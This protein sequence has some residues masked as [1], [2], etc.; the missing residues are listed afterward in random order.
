M[1]TSEP[2][3]ADETDEGFTLVEI[4]V[5]IGLLSVV[6]VASL[7]VF[8][9]MLASTATTRLNTQGKNLAQERLEQIRD[10][11]FHVDRQN[12]PFLDLLDLYYTNAKSVGTP[13]PVT[14]SGLTLSGNYVATGG[15]MNG[16]PAAPYYRT[17]TG[18][19]PGALGFSQV[20]AAQFLG[21][22]GAVLPAVRYQDLYD[23]QVVG[24]DSPPS[25]VLGITVITT[26]QQAGVTKTYRTFTQVTEGR[27]EQPVIQSQARAV[28]VDVTSTGADGA[29][30]ELQAG[31]ASVDGA[32]SSGSSVSGFVA[33]AQYTRS[34][35]TSITGRV[36]QFALPAAVAVESGLT[37]PQAPGLCAG[38]AFGTTGVDNVT[39]DVSGGLPKAP[40]NVGT[41]SSFNKISGFVSSTGGV[42]ACG[43]LSYDNLIG[44]GVAI[45]SGSLVGANFGPA[46]YVRVDDV[47]GSSRAISGSGYV[48][49]NDLGSTPQQT[50]AG[51]STEM[52]KEVKIFPNHPSAF[53]LGTGLVSAKLTSASV[54]CASRISV[55]VD[56]TVIGK[57][58]L[59][60]S[61]WGKGTADLVPRLHT[62]N[63][64]Y[65]ST[66]SPALT[67]SGDSWA[68]STTTLANG[69]TLS[70]LVQVV[71]PS[72][73]AGST[74]GNVTTGAT[75][76]LRGFP[77]GVLTMTT[78]PT[79]SNEA[80]AGFSAIKVQLGQL[81]CVADDQ[82]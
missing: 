11:R 2:R 15:A 6:M 40:A 17:S 64:S 10:L 57:Y 67:A 55:P 21:P 71:V 22:T 46:P 53:P 14:A 70:Q 24:V 56:G 63:W 74:S 45:P 43:L 54:D 3:S 72:A 5:A 82:R 13:T 23:S 1:S 33:G 19:I 20:I 47:S 32:Q 59:L 48:T 29:T 34:G 44:G 8:I 31:V 69:A 75:T 62:A 50:S 66:A 30:L 26:W 9:A 77:N 4:L 49:A 58:S 38:Y 37:A 81:T 7:P 73:V 12:G 16:L 28:A 25:L 51:A 52:T 42:H 65:D 36:G 27:P 61:W 79:L 78:T 76:G 60:L 41:G 35:D 18:P 80:G 68:P 39:G